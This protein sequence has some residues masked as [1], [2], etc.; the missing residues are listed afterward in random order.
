MFGGIFGDRRQ[1]P[2]EISAEVS[3][4]LV[5]ADETVRRATDEL[6]Y[7]TAEFGET[8]TRELSSALTAAERHLREAFRLQA[9][10]L[11]DIQETLPEQQRLEAGVLATTAEVQ[12]LLR[13]PLDAFAARRAA[14]REA[15]ATIA[16]LRAELADLRGRVPEARAVAQNLSARYSQEAMLAVSDNPDQAEALLGFTER[17]LALAERRHESGRADEATKAIQV[18]SESVRRAAD[19]LEAVADFEVETVH[20]E[21]TLAAVL[22]DSRSDVTEARQLLAVAPD[23]RLAEA[24]TALDRAV[25]EASQ[26]NAGADPF[27]T[28]NRLRA[29]NEALE[30]LVHERRSRPEQERL[31]ARLEAALA[32][33]DRQVA[34]ARAFIAD[35]AGSVGPDARTRL[36]QAER[37][38]ESVVHVEDSQTA[39]T[40][41]RQ[42]ADLAAAAAAAAQHDVAASQDRWHTDGAGWS[43]LGR[44][45]GGGGL[46]GVL[47]GVLGGMVLGGVLDDFDMDFDMDFD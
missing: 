10:L 2:A 34:L 21:S 23:D 4:A 33:A 40:Q 18:A 38:L 9:L 7:A 46:G 43:D 6:G 47:G 28:L 15:P 39:L 12:R 29:A 17:S 14:L 24:A 35:H 19:L 44:G 32:D 25:G 36:A 30:M 27:T 11:D 42:A 16:R 20:A 3:A 26:P 13:Q 37:L 8:S 41:V 1:Q 45:R 22:A 5:R 31:R